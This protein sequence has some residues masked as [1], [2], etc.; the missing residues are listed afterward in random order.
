MGNPEERSITLYDPLDPERSWML[1]GSAEDEGILGAIVN[2]SGMYEVRLVKALAARMPNDGVVLDVGANIGAITLPLAARCPAGIVHAF[3]PVASTRRFLERN[4]ASMS[5]VKIHALGFGDVNRSQA[6]HINA[7]HPGGAHTRG[8]AEDG[9]DTETIEMTTLDAW[10]NANA[11]DRIDLIKLDVEGDE[12]AFLAGADQTLRRFRPTIA[13]ECNPVTLW[14]YAGVGPSVLIERLAAVYGEVGWIEEDGTALRLTGIEQALSELTHHVLIDLMCGTSFPQEQALRP[15]TEPRLPPA[16][17][18][19]KRWF[20]GSRRRAKPVSPLETQVEVPA[21]PAFTFI[22]TPSYRAKFVIDGLRASPGS[23][24]SLP[25]EMHNTSRFWFWSHWPH[26]V[27]ASYRWKRDGRVVV[28]DGLRTL[29]HE[30]I[31]PGSRT[32]IHL[33]VAVPDAPGEY[34]LVFSLVQEGYAWFDHLRA[35]LGIVLPVSVR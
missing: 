33:D 7:R 1:T 21:S 26:P 22:H 29:L 4:T 19:F 28:R 16:S 15:K 13:V 6:I 8:D 25:V 18:F 24:L 32:L 35:E 11:V 2:S 12:I 17:S 23:R 27:T 3:E 20:G 9:D 31:A 30:P 14:R 10:V 5:N 34:E